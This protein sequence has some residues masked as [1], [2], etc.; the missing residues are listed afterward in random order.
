L[1]HTSYIFIPVVCESGNIEEKAINFCGRDRL[2]YNAWLRRF[3]IVFYE[4]CYFMCTEF[5]CLGLSSI[6]RQFEQVLLIN[7]VLVLLNT[8]T[9]MQMSST[10]FALYA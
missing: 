7:L 5:V 3:V 10:C 8:Q 9:H 4:L 6:Q 2:I 1:T